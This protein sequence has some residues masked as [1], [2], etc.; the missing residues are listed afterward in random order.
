M[1]NNLPTKI[2]GFGGVEKISFEES[3]CGEDVKVF[4]RRIMFFIGLIV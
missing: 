2:S 1:K 4:N 3:F